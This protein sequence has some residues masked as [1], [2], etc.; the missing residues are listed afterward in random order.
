M[1][2][3]LI[4]EKLRL[5]AGGSLPEFGAFTRFAPAGPDGSRTLFGY[6]RMVLHF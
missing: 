3:W 6:A 5:E 1:R 4:P 2:G